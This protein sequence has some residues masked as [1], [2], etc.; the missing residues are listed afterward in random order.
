M[1]NLNVG[2]NF[3]RSYPPIQ[4]GIGC[5]I[6][7]RSG[8]FDV[9]NVDEMEIIANECRVLAW[10]DLRTSVEKQRNSCEYLKSL[11]IIYK[12]FPWDTKKDFLP[13]VP[14][15]MDYLSYYKILLEQKKILF[16]L[17][18]SINEML[19]NGNVAISCYAGKDRTGVICYLIHFMLNSTPQDTEKDYVLSKDFLLMKKESFI[20]NARKKNLN[21]EQYCKRFLLCSEI[22]TIFNDWF[23]SQFPDVPSFL[24]YIGLPGCFL[25][26]FQNHFKRN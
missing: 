17:F 7:Y 4:N 22:Y 11:G 18:I 1:N 19:V 16:E 9:L 20:H 15:P 5:P 26:Q 21:L 3:R 12:T 23:R 25:L 8:S 6:I 14:K 24:S 2:I 10:F 13:L